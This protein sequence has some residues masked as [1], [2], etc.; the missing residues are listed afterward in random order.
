MNPIENEA[1]VQFVQHLLSDYI[2][3]EEITLDNF[4][5]RPGLTNWYFIFISN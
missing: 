4:K 1:V 5:L 3:L 2:T